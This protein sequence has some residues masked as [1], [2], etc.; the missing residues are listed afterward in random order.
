M[1]STA[2]ASVELVDFIF[3]YYIMCGDIIREGCANYDIV[4]DILILPNNVAEVN[5]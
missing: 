3:S 2:A 4:S 1:L 5:L